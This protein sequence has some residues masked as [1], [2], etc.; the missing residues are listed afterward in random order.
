MKKIEI[1]DDGDGNKYAIVNGERIKLKKINHCPTNHNNNKVREN[2]GEIYVDDY[3]V[4]EIVNNN[5]KYIK[6]L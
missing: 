3:G 2:E 5:K 4:Y 6:I 1:L